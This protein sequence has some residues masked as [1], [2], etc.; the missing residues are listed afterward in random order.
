MDAIL[1]YFDVALFRENELDFGTN[2][3]IKAAVKKSDNFFPLP[4]DITANFMLDGKVED[5]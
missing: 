2:C 3:D 5:F 4:C 1:R